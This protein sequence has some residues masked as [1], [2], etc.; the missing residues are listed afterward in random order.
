[1]LDIQHPPLQ[2]LP[3]TSSLGAARAAA[4]AALAEANMGTAGFV[5]YRS[6]SNV[7]IFGPIERALPAARVLADSLN[8]LL[9]TEDDTDDEPDLRQYLLARGR[10][11]LQG[12]LG[13]FE[14]TLDTDKGRV[15]L[16]AMAAGKFERFDQVLDLSDA[17]L[18]S[19]E[20]PPIGYQRVGADAEALTE[21][22]AL[23]P[24]M[25][26]EFQ[27]PKF[28]AYDEH[29][30]AHGARGISGCTRCLDACATGAILSRGEGI[31]VDP[32]LCQGCGSCATVCPSGAISYAFPH[33]RDLLGGL[34]RALRVFAEAGAQTPPA[35]LFHGD[36]AGAE[37][38]AAVADQ[39]PEQLLPV[40][41]EDVGS[42]GP[43]IW[44]T[45]FAMG[46]SDVLVLLGDDA[47]PA[48]VAATE[49]Q[50]A[51]FS[52]VLE[53]LQ[54]AADRVRL[55]HG[56]QA[57]TAFATS[58]EL[59]ADHGRKAGNFSIAGGKRERLQVAFSELYRPNR[60]EATTP[61]AKGAPFGQI[62]VDREA[63]TLCMACAAVCPAEAV[64][65]GGGEPRLLFDESAC[66]QCGLCEKACPED[67][68][69]L[70]ARLHLPAFAK[71]ETRVLN[72][73]VPFHCIGC[74]KAFATEKMIG[75][76]AEQLAGHWMFQDDRARRRLEM[77]EDCRVK[78][79]FDEEN[80]S[81]R[82]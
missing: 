12:H 16:A 28:F 55:L 8:C 29:I 36:E 78:D 9:V 32:Y 35:L 38:V 67:A 62:I 61:L 21:A 59:H 75:R 31:E 6:G 81:L 34:R 5:E 19:V 26:G 1:M 60:D 68:I 45:A 70:E 77:C 56:Q 17:P 51:L 13:A 7:L 2:D 53:A 43:D 42:I 66:L 44:L 40:A 24:E 73:E 37:A 72:E 20:K 14:A 71:P 15:N 33:A 50:H 46:A 18:I 52:P 69:S 11:S 25:V 49:T 3:A 41:V 39:L 27:K 74:G 82:H 48:L 57:L 54:L 47:E 23:I 76:V 64:T 58:Q 65:S 22:L 80:S 10:P 30:C 63:C 4:L 79:L